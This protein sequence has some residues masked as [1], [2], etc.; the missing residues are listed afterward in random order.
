MMSH[1]HGGATLLA[2]AATGHA[3]R[4]RVGKN[5]CTSLAA[6]LATVTKD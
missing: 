6:L 2:A 4:V 1:N 5:I 3:D